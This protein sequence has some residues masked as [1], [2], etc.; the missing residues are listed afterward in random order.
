MPMPNQTIFQ[1]IVTEQTCGEACWRAKEPSCRCSCGGRNH[2]CL[3]NEDGEQPAR[4]RKIK[5]A[6]YQLAAVQ[7]YGKDNAQQLL[8]DLQRKIENAGITQGL[9]THGDLYWAEGYR[10]EHLPVFIKTAN[11]GEVNRWPE[12]SAW[13]DVPFADAWNKPLTLWVRIDFMNL[14]PKDV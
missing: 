3:V 2:S 6:M 4:T 7:T 13:R 8:F 12:L 10:M 14:V 5:G 1:A 9:F 11:E